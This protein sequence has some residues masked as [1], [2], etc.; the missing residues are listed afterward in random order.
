MLTIEREPE[1]ESIQLVKL[2][3]WVI[4]HDIHDWIIAN[5]TGALGYTHWQVRM[6]TQYN[7]N[8]MKAFFTKAHIEECSDTW[9]YERKDGNFYSSRDTI[10][11]LQQRFAKLRPWQEQLMSIIET[12][13]DRRIDVVYNPSAN[14]GKSFLIGHLWETGKAHC[15]QGQNN[16]K[17]I[18]QDCASEFIQNGW[19]PIVVIDIPWSWKWTNDLYIALE[20]IKDG[21]IKDTRF[22]S[23]TI[24]IHGVKVLVMCNSKPNVS[25]LARDRWNILTLEGGALST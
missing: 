2:L 14:E 20:R 11:A 15:I 6:R 16:A 21:L 25:K 12:A 3:Q 24:N 10:G 9:N 8:Q 1:R 4:K 17:G 7:F 23:K 5:E 13:N 22:T 18:V 19:R